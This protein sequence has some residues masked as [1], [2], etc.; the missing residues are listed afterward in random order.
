MVYADKKNEWNG[1]L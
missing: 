1:Q